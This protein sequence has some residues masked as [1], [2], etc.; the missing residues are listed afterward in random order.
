MQGKFKM[1]M[2]KEKYVEMIN[3]ICSDM[4]YEINF[5]KDD[6]KILTIKERYIGFFEYMD[7]LFQMYKEIKEKNYRK[8]IEWFCIISFTIIYVAICSIIFFLIP[9][10]HVVYMIPKIRDFILYKKGKK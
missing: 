5:D 4:E 2:S 6:G 7:S 3:K 8:I 1:Q 10:V 9:I